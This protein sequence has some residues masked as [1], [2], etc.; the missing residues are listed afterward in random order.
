MDRLRAMRIFS[1]VARAGSLSAAARQLGQPL[2]TVSRLLAAL[3]G[4]LGTSLITRTTRRLS[5][6]DAGRDYLEI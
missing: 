4:H 2:T 3:E 5:L 1:T 6:T